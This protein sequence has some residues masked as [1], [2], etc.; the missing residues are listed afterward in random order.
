MDLAW[1][2]GT[3]KVYANYSHKVILDEAKGESWTPSDTTL[4][5]IIDDSPPQ[6]NRK[7]RRTQASLKRRKK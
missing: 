5:Y 1:V 7:E 2:G 6:L 3:K 4:R